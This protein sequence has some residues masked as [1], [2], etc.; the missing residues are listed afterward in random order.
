M[1]PARDRRAYM[2]VPPAGMAVPAMW[3]VPGQN[4]PTENPHTAHP[5]RAN[6]GQGEKAAM[7]KH[8]VHRTALPIIILQ[9]SILPFHFP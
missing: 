8:A 4:I 2:A 9:R 5:R 7:A 1:S 3:N 6:A